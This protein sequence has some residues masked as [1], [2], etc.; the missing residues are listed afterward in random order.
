[1]KSILLLLTTT[2]LVFSC[3]KRSEDEGGEESIENNKAAS[4]VIT[5]TDVQLK[6]AG[7]ELG[8]IETRQISGSIKVSG[9]LD[10]PPQQLV[11]VSVPLGGFLK[12]TKLLEGSKVKKGQ[13]IAI[14]ENLDFIQIQQDYLEAKNQLEVS[15]LDYDRQQQLARENV[16]SQ[17]VLQQAKATHLTWKAK[18][19]ALREKIRV[20]NLN[21]EEIERGNIRSTINLF[22]P[23]DGYVTQVNVNIGKFVN[24]ADVI[25]KIVDTEHL[26]AELIVFEKDVPK[27]RIGQKV[28]F[29]LANETTERTATVYLIG[30]E[31]GNDRTIQVHCHIDKEDTELLPGMFLSAIVETGGNRVPALPVEAIADFQGQSHVFVSTGSDKNSHTFRIIPIKTGNSEG[32]FVEVSS[33]DTLRDADIVVKGAYGIL[34]K[35]KNVEE[36]E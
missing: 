17:K 33:D 16:N 1:M 18:F 6:S 7:V 8:K 21:A 35:L 24:P 32:G 27:L 15:Q 5:L 36:G 22:S 14:I 4:S 26:H 29:T 3:E 20:L 11:T 12:D 28:R 13:Q 23:I 2:I 10:V 30:R 19:T 25:F 9:V 31:I 34:A